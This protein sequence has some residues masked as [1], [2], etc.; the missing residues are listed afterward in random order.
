MQVY[1]KVGT[2]VKR[3]LPSDLNPKIMEQLEA[4]F[5]Q[6]MEVPGCPH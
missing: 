3:H 1:S 4:G 2:Q 5:V 6:V